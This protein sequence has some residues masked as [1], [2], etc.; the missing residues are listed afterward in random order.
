PR[1]ERGAPGVPRRQGRVH[2]VDGG[3]LAGVEGRPAIVGS[4]LAPER[5]AVDG[6]RPRFPSLRYGAT[7]SAMVFFL[8][9]WRA[10]Y[11]DLLGTLPDVGG[12]GALDLAARPRLLVLGRGVQEGRAG[13]TVWFGDTAWPALQLAAFLG[14]HRA[15][16][17][18]PL[19]ARG[20]LRR[21]PL[22]PRVGGLDGL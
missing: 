22:R 13:R 9:E 7:S 8:A 11:V 18:A 10:I 16:G 12:L 20:P 19:V 1:A 4:P 14:L 6:Q 2:V 21:E 5:L 17:P 3:L 15:G